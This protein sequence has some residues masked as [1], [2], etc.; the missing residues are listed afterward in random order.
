MVR[1]LS[2]L[3][4]S[5]PDRRA[6]RDQAIEAWLPMAYRLARRYAR[7]GD[8]F[9]DLRQVATIGLIK[10]VDGF[11]A[12]RGTD[13]PG[14]AIPTITG[15]MKRY[16]R[17]RTWFLRV[18][19]RLQELRLD[20]GA[21][22][23]QLCNSLGRSPT[24][25]DIAGYLQVSED[26]VLEG[27]ESGYA[28]RALSLSNPVGDDPGLTLGDTIGSTDQ[29]YASVE[30]HV[31]MP[32]VLALLTERERQIIILRFYGNLTQ[33]SI[34]EKVGVSQMHVSRILTGALAKL[35]ERLVDTS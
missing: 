17:D 26:A 29:G 20:I 19:R 9:D 18:P 27:L 12:L 23:T 24:V 31:A 22:R 10:A 2:A 15:E 8:L 4:P 5:H 11:D 25:A 7:R 30:F 21:A 28:Y 6:L 13:F 34:A 33:G 16:F 35:R 14:Y 1:R 3:P 32:P